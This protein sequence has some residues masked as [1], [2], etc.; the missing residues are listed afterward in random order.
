MSSTTRL[1]ALLASN[2]LSQDRTRVFV[3]CPAKQWMYEIP[4]VLLDKDP[5][6]TA[7]ECLT[8]MRENSRQFLHLGC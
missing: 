5:D 6:D 4:I 1:P 3:D 2:L 7:N 8:G